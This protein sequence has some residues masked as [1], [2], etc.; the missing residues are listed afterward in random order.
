M[1]IKEIKVIVF[2]G[3]VQDIQ[4]KP[5]GIRVKVLDYDNEG[6]DE[7]HPCAKEING[8]W[9]FVGIWEAS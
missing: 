5:E 6:I 9:I 2:G 3:L 4:G 8:E 7:E 1:K